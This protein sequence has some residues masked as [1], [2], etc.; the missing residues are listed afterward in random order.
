MPGKSLKLATLALCSLPLLGLGGC[1]VKKTERL[2]AEKVLTLRTATLEELV[3]RLRQQAEAVTFIN[4]QTELVPSTGSAYS[5]VIEEYHDVRAFVLA[6][7]RPEGAANRHHIRVIGQA[8]LVRKNI[9]DMA[10]DDREFRIFLPTKNKFI[11]GPTRLARRSE[12]PI[13]NLRPQHLLEALFLSAPQRQPLALLFLEENEFA[14]RRYYAVTEMAQP[15][16]SPEAR[17]PIWQLSRKWWF[18]RTD[19]SLVRAQRF[20]AEG[21]LLA[22]VHYHGWGKTDGVSYPREIELVRPQEDYRLKL[23]VKELKL[24]QPLPAERF[25]LERPAGVELVELNDDAAAA[26]K[27]E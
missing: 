14:G 1:G 25:E 27:T 6:E 20:D 12:K 13:E 21:R 16:D 17:Y 23:L 9:F 19:L 3:G 18:D 26:R 7:R 5:G 22:D 10:A 4:A 2:P 15:E 24:N 11:V 8:P